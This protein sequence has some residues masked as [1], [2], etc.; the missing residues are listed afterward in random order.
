MYFQQVQDTFSKAKEAYQQHNLLR[1]RLSK[2]YT[3]GIYELDLDE[4]ITRYNGAYQS[5]TR[6]FS[7]GFRGDQKVIAKVAIDGR[8]PKTVL[9][10]LI[11]AR[12]VKALHTEIE[13][14]AEQVKGLMGHF[15]RG[16]DTDFLRAEKAINLTLELKQLSW[17]NPMPENLLKLI[18]STSNPSPMIKHLGSELQES[19]DRW[20]QQTKE[21]S[22]LLPERLPNS[23][24]P[25]NQTALPQLEEWAIDTEKQLAPLS[26]LTKET[27]STAK[28][29]EPKNYKLLIEDL[30][31][32]EEV[33]KKEAQITGEKFQLQIKFGSRFAQLETDWLDILAVLEWVKKVQAAFGDLV[34]P[35]TFA[36]IAAQGPANA[37]PNTRLTKHYQ[38]ALQSLASLE[39]RFETELKYQN[40][41]L[42]NW[43]LQVIFERIKALRER[44]DEL[45]VW[46]DFKDLKNRFALRGLDGFFG[47]LS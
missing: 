19:I 4:L 18:T 1:D 5:F 7:P 2:S 10:D 14:Q 16:Y 26:M 41:K 12:K 38:T 40:E 9:N 24:L 33:R 35:A 36:A 6:M 15:Y 23:E 32:A 37:P 44:V 34:V 43:E 39:L 27:L 30:V 46:I 21:V 47:T 31:N 17:A 22:T 13:S 25:L 8:V 3:A 20:E 45:Q 42:R 11:D 28:T 29:E